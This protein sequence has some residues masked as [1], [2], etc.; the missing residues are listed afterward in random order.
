MRNAPMQISRN[1]IASIDYL[2]T[3]E[4]QEVDSSQRHG[5]MAYLHG[6]G[7]IVPGLERALEGKAAGDH[8]NVTLPP[9]E[10]YGPRN[11]SLVGSVPRS[12]FQGVGDIQKGMRFQTQQGQQ[13]HTVMVV[14]VQGETV[15]VD[16]N[17]PLA[18]KN[19]DFDVTVRDVRDATPEE[20][21]HGH[22]HGPDGH[23]GH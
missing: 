16:A 8:F 5:P 1:K 20:L 4:G 19:L 3:V 21:A 14:D 12:A 17:H 7:S 15:K 13:V 2:L 6:A 23:S 11:E 9:G 22:A 18:G 10:A